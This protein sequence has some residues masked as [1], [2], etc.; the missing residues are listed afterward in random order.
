MDL[1]SLVKAVREGLEAEF[2]G[3]LIAREDSGMWRATRPGWSRLWASSSVELRT[4][5]QQ[6]GAGEGEG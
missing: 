2:P 3:W 1:S 4:K 6:V 5:I